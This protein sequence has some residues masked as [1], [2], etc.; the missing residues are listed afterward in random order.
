DP[1]KVTPIL[2]NDIRTS[3]SSHDSCSH[4]EPEK[5]SR[6]PSN[7]STITTNPETLESTYDNEINESEL[8]RRRINVE[9][10]DRISITPDIINTT[11]EPDFI[12]EQ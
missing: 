4:L 3:S 1:F 12:V 5:L 11:V 8:R 2:D 9:A 10:A 7:T 6:I